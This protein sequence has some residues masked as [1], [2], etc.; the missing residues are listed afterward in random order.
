MTLNL[1]LSPELEDR[2]RQEAVRRGVSL[3]VA[4]IELLD[5]HLP[6]EADARRTAAV[7]MLRDWADEDQSL[8]DDDAAD[9]AA[10]LRALDEHRAS[11]RKLFKNLLGDGVGGS[12]GIA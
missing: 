9:N 3:D 12:A 4:T 8:S 1:S 6:R 5:E 10:V 2:L 11:Y 7:A